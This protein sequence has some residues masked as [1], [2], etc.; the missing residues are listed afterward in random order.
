MNLF[1]ANS[2]RR[3]AFI[4]RSHTIPAL[5]LRSWIKEQLHAMSSKDKSLKGKK[6]PDACNTTQ[7]LLIR[8]SIDGPTFHHNY[9]RADMNPVATFTQ[10]HPHC[11]LAR[12][13]P[14]IMPPCHPA[15]YNQSPHVVPPQRCLTR[16]AV[17]LARHIYNPHTTH[18]TCGLV[19]FR[20]RAA[21]TS[22][23]KGPRCCDSCP[24]RFQ[25]TSG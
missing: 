9:T 14:F 20:T 5:A 6:D 22:S 25:H 8:L 15:M 7:T 18:R 1:K 3:R 4:L 12:Y 10:E 21:N 13:S 16:S 17:K 2:R 24:R 11:H 23:R 19:A